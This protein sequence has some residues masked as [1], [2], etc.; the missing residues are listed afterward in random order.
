MITETRPTTHQIA[1]TVNGA[2]HSLE[3]EPRLL[4]VHMLREQG[5][6][7]RNI[8]PALAVFAELKRAGHERAG[9]PLADDDLALAGQR[10][11]GIPGQRRLGV[12]CVQM[13]DAAAHEQ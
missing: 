11:A 10:L 1:V 3:V 8:H 2:E 12:E 7:L 5:E 13:A 9:I 4:L 6:Y